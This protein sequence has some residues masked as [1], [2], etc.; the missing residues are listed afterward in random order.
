MEQGP[1]IR[2]G[3][4]IRSPQE[5]I[6]LL[7]V[8]HIVTDL[9]SLTV[10]VDEL[11]RL[12]E[13]EKNGI[14]ITLPP[15][16]KQYA[17]YVS[18]EA[19]MLASPEG[20]RLWAYWQQQLPGELPILNLH[21]DRPRPSM[22]SYRGATY[23]C[24]F[25]VELTQ[26]LK[27]FSCD[28]QVTLYMTLLAAFQ[29]LLYRYTGQE[30]I[31]VGSPTSGRHRAAW[32]GVVGYLVNPVVLR[33]SFAGNPS[34]ETFL[35]QV[36]QTVLDAFAHQDYPFSLIVE[37]LVP[38]RD[39]GRSP[40]FQVMFVLQ[41]A[42]IAQQ[43]GLAALALGETGISMNLGDLELESWGLEQQI[44]QFELTLMM[45]EIEGVLTASWQYNSDLFD[46][47]SIVRMAGHFQTLLASAITNP[48]Q[49]IANLPL[50]TDAEQHQ[51]LSPSF[52]RGEERG[53]RCLHE[54][55]TNQ[56]AQTPDAVAI[57][58]ADEQLTY[59]Q[60][61]ARANQLAHYLQSL[62]VEPEF[63]VGLC[64]ERSLEMIIGILGI[65][66]AGGAYIPLD[67]NYP[68]ERLGFI[69]ADANITILVTQKQ[70]MEKLPT[71]QGFIVCFD[72]IKQEQ[73]HN[74]ISEVTADNLAYIIYTSGSTGQPKGVLVNHFHVVRLFSSTDEWFKFNN[75]DV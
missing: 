38:V 17:D 45:A 1:L 2:V 5:Y 42:Q 36:Q 50:L 28:R 63:K 52:I 23:N 10:L 30:D 54:L 64:V 62:G 69:L 35:Q 75:H 32:A 61:N 37:Q 12:Y 27:D 21:T 57:T 65:I 47:D 60:L 20:N 24:K 59:Q 18:A 19:Q 39:L 55:F 51:I 56:V 71:F 11:G 44:A 33:A 4:F 6:F 66:K 8:H 7:V 67:P 40:L 74:P 16:T 15:L 41:K 48:V 3:L 14:P 72:Q 26:K 31:L 49:P 68:Q 43:A 70:L 25:S 9:W 29:S 46:S 73:E 13:A 53:V 22:Q 34:F 58:F